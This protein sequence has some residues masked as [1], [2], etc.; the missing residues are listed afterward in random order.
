MIYGIGTDIFEVRR[1]KQ[2]LADDEQFTTAIF[3]QT[4]IDYCEKLKRKEEHYAARFAAK[5]AFLK[6]LGTGWRFGI[7]FKDIEIHNNE[8][9]KP[10]IVLAGKAKE[11][12]D[13]LKIA[14]VHLS[15]SHTS[16]FAVAYV[17]LESID[18]IN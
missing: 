15:V 2:K 6:A 16:D 12:A 17:V 13:E 7:S 1:I 4:E 10:N 9:G 3:T 5:E 18:F 8:L 14:K 11:F